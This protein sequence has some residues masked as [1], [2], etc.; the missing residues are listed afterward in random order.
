[1][2]RTRRHGALARAHAGRDFAIEP[3]T[4]PP[5]HR[6][7]LHGQ[8]GPSGER[9]ERTL[10]ERTDAGGVPEERRRVEGDPQARDRRARRRRDVAQVVIAPSME[11]MAPVT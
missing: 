6:E 5:A 3:G 1:M 10:T 11:R 7:G 8:A 9:V 4:A 2:Q